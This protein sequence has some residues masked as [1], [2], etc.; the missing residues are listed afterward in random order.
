MVNS[1]GLFTI[2]SE[3]IFMKIDVL[4]IYFYARKALPCSHI[5]LT[6]FVPVSV[7]VKRKKEKRKTKILHL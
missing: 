4:T 1:L 3:A 2:N 6:R 5:Y 7:K